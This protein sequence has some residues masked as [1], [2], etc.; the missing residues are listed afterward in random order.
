MRI[1]SLLLISFSCSLFLVLAQYYITRFYIKD[2]S[3]D[4]FLVWSERRNTQ[5]VTP[6]TN[7]FLAGGK[8]QGHPLA[9][10]IVWDKK[11]VG[12]H[13]PSGMEEAGFPWWT[14]TSTLGRQSRPYSLGDNI[15]SMYCI[16][17]IKSFVNSFFFDNMFSRNLILNTIR[18]S[19]DISWRRYGKNKIVCFLICEYWQN[20]MYHAAQNERNI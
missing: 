16:V 1:L 2:I 11:V 20:K 10:L 3:N 12:G 15:L 9:E 14:H 8:I 18:S 4:H 5:I 13:P 6:K 17:F 7:Y 19:I